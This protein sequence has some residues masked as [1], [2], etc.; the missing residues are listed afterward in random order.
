MTVSQDVALTGDMK[1]AMQDTGLSEE[2]L[3][4]PKEVDFSLLL[5]S[6]LS[7]STSLCSLSHSVWDSRFAQD[8]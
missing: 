2:F 8:L 1:T 4:A 5:S 6:S 3:D 7:L